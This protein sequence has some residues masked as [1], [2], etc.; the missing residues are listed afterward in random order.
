MYI[1]RKKRKTTKLMIILNQFVYSKVT[2]SESEKIL[3]PY[4]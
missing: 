3:K 1:I 4:L 2:Y